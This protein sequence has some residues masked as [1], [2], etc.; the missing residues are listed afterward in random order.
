MVNDFFGSC[1]NIFVK[2]VDKLK[3]PKFLNLD[4]KIQKNYLKNLSF[5]K[6]RNNNLILQI[7][8]SCNNTFP[9]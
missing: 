1:K 9:Q 2:T 4:K 6:M 3:D 5:R 8:T 7:Q